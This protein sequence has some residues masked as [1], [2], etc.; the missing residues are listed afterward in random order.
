M[1]RVAVIGAGQT[2]AS[3]ALALAKRGVEVTLYSDRSQESLRN[4]VP[5]TGTAIIFKEAQQ[6]ERR[7]GLRTYL[8]V[9]PSFTG[10]S[11][12]VVAEPNVELIAYDASFDGFRAEGVDTRL[13]ADDRISEFRS[14]GGVFAVRKVDEDA[15][16]GIAGENDLT[17]VATGKFGLSSIFPRDE[18][19]SFFRSPQRQLL[20]LTV[21]GLGHDESVFAHHSPAGGAHAVF[22]FIGDKG[23]AWWGPYYHKDAGPSWSFLGWAKPGSEWEARFAAATSAESAL[24]IVTELHRDYLPWD[25]PEV[26]QFKVI[27]DD[28]HSWLRGGVTPA[29]RLGVGR[30]KSRRPVAALGD[31]AIS[32]DPIAAQ[33]AQSGFIQAA[34]YV[35]KIVAHNGPF[36]ETW[37]RNAHDAFYA[38][39]GGS[40][41]L[42]TRLFLG[43]P[44]LADIAQVF[45]TAANGSPRF[46]AELF[47]LIS[48][49]RPLL[50][51][52]SVDDAKALITWLSGEK[53]DVVLE[54]SQQRIALAQER[55]KG[56][57][58]YFARS[59]YP[60]ALGRT[61]A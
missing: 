42:V 47:G 8:D 30:T 22:S 5:A 56:G 33:G 46:A 38:Q 10:M 25:L 32:Y 57:L 15:L 61:A 17:L 41:E 14:L 12:T 26:L 54:R 28:P 44:D 45:I 43:Y 48:D 36:D 35:E 39:R 23:E 4:D 7:L 58:E 27:A 49:P 13:K 51:V 19:R 55:N 29:V 16:D 52:R 11:G 9:A 37:I 59:N 2:G 20:M 6:A 40:A 18:S 31:T 34:I 50:A 24:R 21:S 3:T 60:G 53:A 1:T